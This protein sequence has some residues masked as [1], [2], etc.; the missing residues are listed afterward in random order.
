MPRTGSRPWASSRP[1]APARRR[2]PS[3][4]DG[5]WIDFRGPPGTIP[6][7]SFADLIAGTAD[8]A[9]LRG[10]VVVVGAT[11]PTLGDVH[12]TPTSNDRLMSGAEVQANAIWTALHGLPMRD[13][14]PWAGWIAIAFMGLVPALAAVRGRA[15]RGALVAPLLGLAW[16]IAVEFFFANGIILPVSYPLIALVLGTLTATT[17]A[18]VLEREQRRRTSLYSELLERE[19][20]AR[21]EELRGDAARDRAAARPRGRVTRCRHRR[22]RRPHERAVRAARAGGGHGAGGGRADPP[23]RA[24]CTTSASWASPTAYCASRAGSTTPS[25]R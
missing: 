8:T 4:Q 12:P 13:A 5:A 18:F 20:S 16:L 22:P 15:L 21:T 19:V 23:R 25:G 1:G 11:A 7:V 3:R 2:A 14:P 6:S 24:R 17:S 9:R 10:R